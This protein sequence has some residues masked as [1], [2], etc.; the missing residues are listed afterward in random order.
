MVPPREH[1]RDRAS[2]GTGLRARSSVCFP[3]VVVKIFA[4][5]EL[6]EA[7]SELTVCGLLFVRVWRSEQEVVEPPPILEEE[8]EH[9]Q[10][11]TEGLEIF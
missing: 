10:V 5:V 6:H 7:P 1:A 3:E 2:Q 4:A 8:G 11:V 9:Q